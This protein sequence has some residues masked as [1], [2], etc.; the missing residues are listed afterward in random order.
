MYY[1]KGLKPKIK[2]YDDR[3][4]ARFDSNGVPKEGSHRVLN[5]I[6]RFCL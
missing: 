6:N 4:N 5:K 2:L 1:G 3:V